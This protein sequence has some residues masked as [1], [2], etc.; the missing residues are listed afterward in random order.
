MEVR[1]RGRPEIGC[2]RTKQL[3]CPECRQPMPR[4][5]GERRWI[6]CDNCHRLIDVWLNKKYDGGDSQVES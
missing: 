4:A 6:Y 5:N 3:S 2:S 1:P